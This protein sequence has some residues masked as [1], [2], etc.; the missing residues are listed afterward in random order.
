MRLLGQFQFF[1]TKRFHKHK[2]STK[3]LQENK[4]KKAAF[5]A[6]KNIQGGKSHLFAY[7]RFYAFCAFA[8]LR[9]CAF[10]AFSAF[11]TFCAFYA[12]CAFCASK[13]FS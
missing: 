4:K 2:K 9:L 10:R 11:C 12:F 13:I 8:R 6:H 3:C 7:L 5:Y 1:F